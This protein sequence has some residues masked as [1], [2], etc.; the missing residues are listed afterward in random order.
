MEIKIGSEVKFLNDVGG[1]IVLEIF[2]D[3]TAVKQVGSETFKLAKLVV[4]DFCLVT[5]DEICAATRD[6]FE[7]T[8]TIQEPAGAMALA[9]L[10]KYVLANGNKKKLS[11]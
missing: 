4:D 8:R 5:A 9:G 2:S 6:I 10:K 11:L 7:D 1:G 3:G